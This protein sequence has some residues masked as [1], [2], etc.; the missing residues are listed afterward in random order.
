MSPSGG[1]RPGSRRRGKSKTVPLWRTSS[2]RG[3]R[4]ARSGAQAAHRGAAH[5]DVEDPPAQVGGGPEVVVGVGGLREAQAPRLAAIGAVR[6]PP[7]PSRSRAP[8]TAGSS[9]S[10]PRAARGGSRPARGYAAEYP[11][12]G[13]EAPLLFSIP[14]FMR[15]DRTGEREPRTVW[16]A[17]PRKLCAL[18]RPGGGGRSHRAERRMAEIE[19][20][21]RR[22][23]RLVVSTMRTR[24]NLAEY[25]AAGLAWHH[26]PV[27]SCAEGADALDELLPLL[28]AELRHGAPWRST[29]TTGRTSPPRSVRPTSTR[30]AAST[31][32]SAYGRPPVPGSRSTAR[33]RR[34]SAS[35]TRT[36]PGSRP[37][38][39]PARP[40]R[41]RPASQLSAPRLS[42][43]AI[44]RGSSAATA[45]SRVVPPDRT[46]AASRRSRAAAATSAS[47]R[48]PT[49]GYARR[50][51]GR[52]PS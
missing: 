41:Q 50:R 24:H 34:C 20:L 38:S 31:R 40:G 3:R 42:A 45:S 46:S 43:I 48:S 32:R 26:V 29:A 7:S 47:S 2:C 10:P 15:R 22:A 49:T 6:R 28:R 16:W 37:R 33:R 23:V 9:G 30:S 51:G 11:A 8:R 4:G 39:G 35:P 25:E 19:W 44:G 27:S 17:R 1:R 21:R 52:A 36:S 14:Q 18:E 5:V 13:G 12:H